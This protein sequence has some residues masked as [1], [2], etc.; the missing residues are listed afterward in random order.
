MNVIQNWDNIDNFGEGFAYFNVGGL[1]G[2]GAAFLADNGVGGPGIG[3]FYNWITST[4]NGF[5]EGKSTD[6]IMASGTMSAIWGGVSGFA[7]EGLAA[8][9]NGLMNIPKNVK[10]GSGLIEPFTGRPQTAQIP[11]GEWLLG[12]NGGNIAQQGIANA[13]VILASFG[14]ANSGRVLDPITEH[15]D[16]SVSL[17]Y[18]LNAVQGKSYVEII[19]ELGNRSRTSLGSQPGGPSLR[20]VVNPLDGNVI[21]MRHML[22]VGYKYGDWGGKIIEFGQWIA[23]NPS[24]MNAQD[25]YSNR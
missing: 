15:L 8:G 5:I 14:S 1:A 20:Y 11:F 21:D 12:S 9:I 25:F 6:E 2:S 18:F 19:N 23:G 24:G 4:G 7:M 17:D 13:E 22:I 16:E 3:M 10:T